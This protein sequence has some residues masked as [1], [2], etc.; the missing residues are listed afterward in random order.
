ML[1]GRRAS[2]ER[3]R[4]VDILNGEWGLG[5]DWGGF[6]GFEILKGG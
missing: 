2:R 1:V 3:R 5:T 6:M 4:R